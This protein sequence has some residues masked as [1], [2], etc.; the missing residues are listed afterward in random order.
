MEEK[1]RR[2]TPS[3]AE[4]GRSPS[5]ASEAGVRDPSGWCLSGDLDLS[6]LRDLVGRNRGPSLKTQKQLRTTRLTAEQRLLMLDTWQ[7]SGLPAKDFAGIVGVSSHTLSSWKR[8]FEKEGP[9]GLI[10]NRQKKRGSS[11]LPELTKR[12]ILMIKQANPDFGCRRISAMLERGPGLAASANAVSRVLHEAGYQLE[13]QP[14]KRHPDKQRRFER[15]RVNQLWQTDLFS[16]VLKRQNR[17]VHLVVYMD[18][19]SRYIVGHGLHM[20]PSAGMVRACRRQAPSRRRI[21]MGKRGRPIKGTEKIASL[22]GSADAKRRLQVIM[23]SISGELSVG[24]ACKEL[25]V[26]KSAFYRM[27]EKAL[28]GALASLEPKEVGRPRTPEPT[29][30]QQYI[31]ELEAKTQQLRIALEAAQIREELAIAMPHVLVSRQQRQEEEKQKQA[32][33]VKKKAARQK[34]KNKQARKARKAQKKRNKG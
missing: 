4:G 31:S 3:E 19:H 20:S 22:E 5:G 6:G 18:D 29:A 13:E 9:E 2:E 23:Q 7:R 33:S 30:D 27:R 16:F 21:A 25:G 32:A 15:P 10:F 17:R 8:R 26:E 14:T 28:S 12:T 34:Q 1:Y 24:E 11:R